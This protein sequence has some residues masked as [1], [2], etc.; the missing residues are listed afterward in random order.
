MNQ[1]LTA[2]LFKCLSLSQGVCAAQFQ[3]TIS[4]DGGRKNL[5]S[6]ECVPVFTWLEW[7]SA[8]S[9]WVGLLGMIWPPLHFETFAH[10]SFIKRHT[11]FAVSPTHCSQSWQEGKIGTRHIDNTVE[12]GRGGREQRLKLAHAF[13]RKTH[14]GQKVHWILTHAQI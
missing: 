4:N 7:P 1:L 3:C 12:G 2:I 8:W 13:S 9:V 11:Q 6:V 5:V 14:F 10:S